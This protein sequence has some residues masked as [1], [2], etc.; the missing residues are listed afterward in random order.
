M[1]FSQRS[2]VSALFFA[3]LACLSGCN[4]GE[5]GLRGVTGATGPAGANGVNGLNGS[6]GQGVS[7]GG[8][9]GQVL[10]KASATDFDTHWVDLPGKATIDWSSLCSGSQSLTSA[11]G[12]TPDCNNA[13]ASSACNTIFN[14]SQVE[15]I[16]NIPLPYNSDSIV[17]FKLSDAANPGVAFNITVANSVQGNGYMCEILN[18][19]GTPGTLYDQS[20]NNV[21]R[22][23]I[24]M[25]GNDASAS[26][27]SDNFVNVL[28]QQSS[29]GTGTYWINNPN[30]PL[31]MM[32][33]AFQVSSGPNTLVPT[34]GCGGNGLSCVSYT[35]Q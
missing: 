22:S 32:C 2:F 21:P 12:C 18:A 6:A 33:V 26:Y 8:T 5:D 20:N 1:T 25:Y 16:S 15:N 24:G 29:G 34:S 11:S 28:A 7:T 23:V 27:Q 35:L 14:A 9:T 4:D 3:G 19:N 17:F 30:N 13:P 31:Y 10:A